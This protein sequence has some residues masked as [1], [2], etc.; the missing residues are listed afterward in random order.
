MLVDSHCH[1]NYLDSPSNALQ[2]A[3]DQGV[4]GFLCIGVEQAT[5]NEVIKIA[6]DEADVWASV[7]QHP[8]AA[9]QDPSWIEGQ[10][11]TL[12]GDAALVLSLIH[13]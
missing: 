5:A 9:A 8:E 7:G 10:L 1:L 13:I 4:S 6:H 2:L 11:S 12:N 3:R